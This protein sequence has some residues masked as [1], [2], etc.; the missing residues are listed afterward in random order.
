M[1]VKYARTKR[2]VRMTDQFGETLVLAIF[3]MYFVAL[4]AGM[5]LLTAVIVGYKLYNRSKN[6]TERRG[7]KT[8]RKGAVNHV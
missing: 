2:R 5:G 8:G 6:K 7:R 4:S 1:A 3:Y